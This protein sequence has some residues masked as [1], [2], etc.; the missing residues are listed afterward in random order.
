MNKLHTL[1]C[2]LITTGLMGQ[3]TEKEQIGHL[4]DNWHKAASQA[5]F[6]AYF[7]KM[8]VES[9]FVGTDASEY[10]GKKEFME[11]SKPYFDRGDAWSFRA[12]QR[13][14]FLDEQKTTAWF[15]ELLDTW[16][17]LCRGSGVL[18]S[19]EGRW[20]IGHYV[21]SIVIPNETVEG[22][23]SLKKEKDSIIKRSML[24]DRTN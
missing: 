10:W 5:D 22:V 8:D 18:V 3:Q 6:D 13:H 21:L 4:L 12:L 1:L 19:N 24:L 15:D 14:I 9:I 23:I 11:F 16:M 17:G 2:L 7:D 20:K